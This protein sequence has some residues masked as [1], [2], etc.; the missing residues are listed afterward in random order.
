MFLNYLPSEVSAFMPIVTNNFVIFQHPEHVQHLILVGPA[1]FSS[2][3]DS[4]SEWV[5]KF[6]A[7]W[8]GKLIN[9]LW[10]S[11]FT[12]QRIVR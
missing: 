1:G 10:E 2:E 3:T 9:H 4:S 12:P 8:K 7:T 11:N 5:T 6:R